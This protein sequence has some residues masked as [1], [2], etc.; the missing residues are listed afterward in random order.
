MLLNPSNLA[1]PQPTPVIATP[2]LD[3]ATARFSAAGLFLV[4]S[5]PDGT[6]AYHDTSAGGFFLKYVLPALK[7]PA[8]LG[9]N[10]AL[11]GSAPALVEI[12][13]SIPGV[14]LAA[15]PSVDKK[16]AIRLYL[17]ARDETFALS[18]DV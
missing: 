2:A 17:A 16:H 9:P 18:E 1:S 11:G 10:V 7:Q 15:L 12:R 6:L 5:H 8:I 14:L 3:A 13:H 4:A